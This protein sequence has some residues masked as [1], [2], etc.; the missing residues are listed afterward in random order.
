MT[1]K[2]VAY[3]L[4]GH[5]GEP[6]S[7]RSMLQTIMSENS[8]IEMTDSLCS[9]LL[10]Q[11]KDAHDGEAAKMVLQSAKVSSAEEEVVRQAKYISTCGKEGNLAE[12]ISAFKRLKDSG[13]KLTTFLYNCLLDACIQCK[14]LESALDYFA[15]MK[16][17]DLVDAVSFNTM[18]KGNLA[19]GNDR[20]ARQVLREMQEEGI[21]ANR[22]TFNVFVSLWV[23]RGA[24]HEILGLVD[25]MVTLRISISNAAASIACLM[26]ACIHN[27]QVAQALNVHD[28]ALN[29]GICTYSEKTYT[30]MA[31]A[32]MQVGEFENA[33]E[34]VR[35]AY[36]LPGHSL[37]ETK[38]GPHG[39]DSSCLADLVSA[40]GYHSITSKALLKDLWHYRRISVSQD[41]FCKN[42]RPQ[43]SS[44]KLRA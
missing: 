26:S 35:C 16:E 13:A 2:A 40:M 37:V 33:V 23:Q 4:R 27:R 10:S 38:N 1:E 44:A 17:Q 12:A 43:K 9:E 42:V 21:V 29:Q 41:S 7:F 5:S 20:T 25:D 3:I 24:F 32:F 14:K 15:E 18:I 30:S 39:V 31:R 36:H 22:I 19:V 28:R 11:C 34:I 8:G 6:A